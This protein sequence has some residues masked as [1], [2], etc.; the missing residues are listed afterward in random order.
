MSSSFTPN[1]SPTAYYVL[2]DNVFYIDRRYRLI[3]AGSTPGL[4]GVPPPDNPAG[5]EEF[6][7]GVI[8]LGDNI[9]PP[10]DGNVLI[11]GGAGISVA[12]NFPQNGITITN[13]VGGTGYLY[14]YYVS[15]NSGSDFFG[16]GSIGSPWNTIAKA[17]TV[18]ATIP[19]TNQVSIIL[20]A[21]VFIENVNITRANTFISGSATSLST[22]TLIAG[23]ITVDLTASTLPFIIGG[24]SS[25]QFQSITYNNSVGNSQS[26]LV[27]DCFIVPLNGSSA[28][29]M[30]DTSAGGT[31]DLTLQSCLIY[32]SDVTAITN[33]NG[34]LTLVNTEV[35]NNISAIPSP[36]SM[37]ITSGTGRVN[38]FGCIITQT[39]PDSTILP[40]VN[41][42]NNA[43][44]ASMTFYN[45]TIQYTSTASDAGSGNKCCIRCSNSATINPIVLFN[46]LL[47]CQGATTTNGTPGQI[48]VLQ[49]TG[50]GT[51]VVSFGQ[52]SGGPT[53]NHLPVNGSGFTK[54]A[55]VNV[56]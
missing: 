5:W 52:N 24:L 31:G 48:L 54:V 50:A 47:L 25:I 20:A 39:S 15:V 9:E 40:I 4:L 42:T 2:G 18:A 8:S 49:R 55:L 1:W 7:T 43:T 45:S 27:T 26:Y 30:T 37:I 19:E 14:N 23:A 17:L 44:T 29:V 22:A 6:N 28:V 35:K 53:A 32:M 11:L 34:F 38:M 12:T 21:G 16:D 56:T 41:L 36:Q 13:T 51:T 10:I 46:C 3:V 33:S